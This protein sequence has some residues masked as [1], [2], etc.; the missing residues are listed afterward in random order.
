MVKNVGVREFDQ[1]QSLK[2][3]SVRV[4]D[5]RK[6]KKNAVALRWS[7]LLSM[8]SEVGPSTLFEVPVAEREL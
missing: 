1:S 4:D 2:N 8:V 5:W 7:C 6:R 3:L